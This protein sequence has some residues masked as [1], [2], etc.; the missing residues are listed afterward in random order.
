[1]I[2][3]NFEQNNFL[4]VIRESEKNIM[5][6]EGEIIASKLELLKAAAIARVYGFSDYKEALNELILNYSGTL[7]AKQAEFTLKNILPKIT[8]PEFENNRIS[9]NYKII[10]PIDYG[11]ENSINSQ[12]EILEQYLQDSKYFDF[13]VTRDFY[14]D[15]FTFVVIHGLKSYEGSLGLIEKLKKIGLTTHETII[16]SDE[17]Y[18]KIQI[19][20]NLGNFTE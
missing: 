18:K 7:E 17:N 6:F 16:S 4:Y 12:I 2:Y 15:N 20:K 19:H 3:S 8:S 14:N 5:N 11:S 13:E 10:F 1:L 9:N